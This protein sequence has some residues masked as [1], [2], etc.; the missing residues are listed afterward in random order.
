M[1]SK[2]AIYYVP[3]LESVAAAKGD[4]GSEA[5]R[6]AVIKALGPALSD[7]E[8]DRVLAKGWQN[9]KGNYFEWGLADLV[10]YKFLSKNVGYRIAAKGLDLLEHV[11]KNPSLQLDRGVLAQFPSFR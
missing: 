5:I 7:S 11:R 2:I 1:A 4:I 6:L 3:I 10:R 8:R 9:S